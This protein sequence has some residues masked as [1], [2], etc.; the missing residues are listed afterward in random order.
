MPDPMLLRGTGARWRAAADR[1]RELAEKLRQL[2][3][4]H[5]RAGMRPGDVAKLSGWEPSQ[6]R[7]VARA[8]GIGP[9]RRGPSPRAT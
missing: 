1:E 8:A 6:V 4:E 9:A 3:I 7:K 5:L 2:V